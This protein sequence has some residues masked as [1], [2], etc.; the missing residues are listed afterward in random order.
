M[1]KSIIFIVA[2]SLLTFGFTSCEKESLGKT[3]VVDYVVLKLEGNA[4]VKLGLGEE[5]IEAGWTATDKG[6]DVHDKVNVSIVD[7]LGQPVDEVTTD[8][9]G[10]FTLT[11]SI[12]SEDGMFIAESRQVLVFDPNL[13]VSLKGSFA[14]DFENSRRLD[15]KVDENWAFWC[16]YYSDEANNGDRAAYVQ[17][18]IDVKF[19]EIV[20]G[21]YNVDDLL[22]GWYRAI[23]GLGFYYAD[24]LGAAYLTYFDMKGMVVLNADMTLDLVSSH[25]DNWDDGLDAFAGTYDP[26]TQT[27]DIH[28]VYGADYNI[29]MV[30]K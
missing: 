13:T 26:S 5:Y 14:V 3:G 25:V 18:S 23:R 17:K 6:K 2:M 29:I 12:T 9:P 21:I 16:A 27:L 8:L 20:P 22:G 10:I 7:M 30:K 15:G 24:N 19:T 1:K 28:S 11:Y 4:T